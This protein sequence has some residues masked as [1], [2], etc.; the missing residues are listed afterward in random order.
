GVPK[1][2][3]EES[4]GVLAAYPWPGNVRELRNAV[5]QSYTLSRDQVI[6]PEHLP[7][8]V[9]LGG[10]FKPEKIDRE[11]APKTPADFQPQTAE[12]VTPAHG[13][14]TPPRELEDRSFEP[15][16]GPAAICALVKELLKQSPD[17]DAYAF[18]LEKFERELLRQS[19]ELHR[20]N[21]V[22][23]AAHLGITRNTLRAKIEKYG[24]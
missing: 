19:L 17:G 2:L 12:S 18:V 1:M 4:I 16:A 21:Q 6:L 13:E 20:H 23:S 9:R 11:E 3:S 15:A 5:E 7:T 24:L 10:S 8:E 22:Q 14:T